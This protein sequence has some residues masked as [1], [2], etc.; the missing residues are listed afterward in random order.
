MRP[1]RRAPAGGAAPE[2][3]GRTPPPAPGTAPSL[4]IGVDVGG[5]FTDLA[6]VDGAG[7]VRTAKALSTPHRPEDAVLEVLG[8]A[9]EGE[10]LTLDGLLARATGLAHGTTT[11]TNALIQRS[12]ARVGLLLTHGFEDTLAIGRGPVGRVGGLAQS[13]AMDFLHTEPPPPLVP[14]AMVRGVRERIGSDGGVVTPLA[15]GQARSAVDE[16]VRSGAESLAVCL[17]W[18]FRNP[19]HERLLAGI[20]RRAAPGLPLSLSSEVAP[21][22]GEFE[23]AVTTAVNAHVGPVT[24]RYLGRLQSRLGRLGPPLRVVTSTGGAIRVEDAGRLAVSIVNS[25]PAGGLA[26]ARDLGAALGHDRII[27]AD[28]GGTSFDA[29]LVHGGGI[30]EDPRPYLAHGLPV[31]QPAA[32]LVTIGAGG[33]SVVWTD[34][35]RLHVGPRSVAA[36]PGPAAYGRGGAL[37][38]VTDALVACGII[39]PDGFFGGRLRLDP[40]RALRAF[41]D[42]VAGPLGMT[43]L[44]AAAG[45]I[46]VVN[47]MMAD[48]LRKVTVEAGHDPRGFT[49]YAYG[50]AT[51]AHCAELARQLGVREVLLPHAGPVFSALGIATSDITYSRAGSGPAALDGRGAA[52]ATRSLGRL[53]EGLAGDVERAGLDPLGCSFRY[54]IEMRHRGQMNEIAVPWPR[55]EVGTA[56]LG[57]LRGLFEAGCEARFGPGVAR[58]G[59][60]LELVG[61]RAEAVHPAPRLPPAP[62][63]EGGRRGRGGVRRVYLRGRGWREAAAAGLADVAAGTPL[64]GPAVIERDTTTIWVPERA[65]ARRDRLGNVLLDVG[66]RPGAR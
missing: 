4:S 38:T 10:G 2:G 3:S 33:G 1:R 18:S 65:A 55:P 40:G 57:E 12:G 28:M 50:G 22:M 63:P 13:E 35:H 58:A 46:E 42:G 54:R 60:P 23:R 37:P 7:R 15:E 53:R 25:G 24:E 8:S 64:E 19:V 44:D 61:Y 21:G 36:D 32:R 11:S 5:T 59:A 52:A 49:L 41:R 62:P 14:R 43:A 51:G 47:A 66:A 17:L 39:D 20:V 31:L 48:L 9:A 30:E 26:A 16:L 56:D 6:M 34:G 29:G 45:A 27:T